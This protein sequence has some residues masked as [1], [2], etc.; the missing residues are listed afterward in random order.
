MYAKHE[1]SQYLLRYDCE[2]NR[3]K[4]LNQYGPLRKFYF[5][6]Q[7]WQLQMSGFELNLTVDDSRPSLNQNHLS[8]NRPSNPKP[9]EIPSDSESENEIEDDDEPYDDAFQDI[10]MTASRT[11]KALSK[12]L[13]NNS[14]IKRN[15]ELLMKIFQIS[16][17]SSQ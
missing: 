6:S 15:F 17:N 3:R 13:E 14:L 11:R 5:Q 10:E 2:M 8:L 1:K 16:E 7:L 12:Y 9:I 4:K